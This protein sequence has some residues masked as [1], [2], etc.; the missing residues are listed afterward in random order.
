MLRG[1]ALPRTPRPVPEAMLAPPVFTLW[2]PL[3]GSGTPAANDVH[4][5]GL[6]TQGFTANTL[7]KAGALQGT[8]TG[9]TYPAAGGITCSTGSGA[10]VDYVPTSTELTLLQEK[11]NLALMSAGE[12]IMVGA[13]LT[14]PAAWAAA[15]TA[16]H[17][18]LSF[19]DHSS[20]SASGGLDFGVNS[21]ERPQVIP[22]AKAATATIAALSP[23]C[24]FCQDSSNHAIVWE[25]SCTAANTFKVRC[26]LVSALATGVTSSAW[27]TA[28]DWSTGNS[29]TGAPGC[30]SAGI[31]LMRRVGTSTNTTNKGETHR[32]IWLSRLPALYEG[33]AARCALEMFQRPGCLPR[34]LRALQGDLAPAGV[35]GNATRGFGAI[36]LADMLFHMD[37]ATDFASTPAV[38]LAIEQG[39]KKLATLSSIAGNTNAG[40]TLW[41]SDST[42]EGV[43]RYDENNVGGM[44]FAR[45]KTGA[46]A[47]SI[48]FSIRK[49][50]SPLDSPPTLNAAPLYNDLNW[51][52][53]NGGDRARAEAKWIGLPVA[54]K[55][56]F[57]IGFQVK[58]VVPNLA[59]DARGQIV[60]FQLFPGYIGS[61][62]T[63]QRPPCTFK[64]DLSNKRVSMEYRY[65]ATSPTYPAD[66]LPTGNPAEHV[67][68]TDYQGQ[69]ALAG[70]LN[71]WVKVVAKIKLS[72]DL[73]DNPIQ[74]VWVDGLPQVNRAERMGYRG[75]SG[76]NGNSLEP[77]VAFGL[78]P[79]SPW[80]YPAQ[81]ID[82]YYSRF[83]ANY[84]DAAG[85]YSEEQI[86]AAITA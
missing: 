83:F 84:G 73:A 12:T 51:S 26:H 71:R 22:W 27:S 29:A 35:D 7:S 74:Q 77:F 72:W 5:N 16:S 38:T 18:V 85:P 76:N 59:A 44:K 14:T 20:G 48:Q 30:G 67:E 4:A 54:S 34:A 6:A 17:T 10:Y 23:D 68:F 41:L 21:S 52:A 25:V 65:A 46:N 8:V 78:Y 62:A 13:Y 1:F 39:A 49:D 42:V 47:N 63:G 58:I 56:T 37:G 24:G 70:F 61:P 64:L 82:A 9:T 40:N 43:R 79:S 60:F 32:G 66:E 80:I 69:A 53:N 31:R 55:R 11:L 57:Y 19:G 3:D 50:G 33:L 15:H 45:W 2:W 28:A 81:T 86:R 75:P 36:P